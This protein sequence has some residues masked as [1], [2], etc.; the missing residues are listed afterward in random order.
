MTERF[1][2]RECGRGYEWLPPRCVVDLQREVRVA[3]YADK[4]QA[5]LDCDERNKEEHDRRREPGF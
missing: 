3:A 2:V 1:Q 4:R 5:E